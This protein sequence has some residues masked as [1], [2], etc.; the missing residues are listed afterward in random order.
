[1]EPCLHTLQIRIQDLN[2]LLANRDDEI[3]GL[4]NEK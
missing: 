1:M 2:R 4:K 3:T